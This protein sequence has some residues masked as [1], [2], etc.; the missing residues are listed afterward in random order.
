MHIKIMPLA[1]TQNVY[2]V[3]IQQYKL[4]LPSAILL[5]TIKNMSTFKVCN[6]K[7]LYMICNL[8]C[9]NLKNLNAL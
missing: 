1:S 9:D 5:Q 4:Q 6:L 8:K 3:I 7:S 2:F